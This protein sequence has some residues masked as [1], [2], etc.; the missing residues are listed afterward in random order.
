MAG[1]TN[2]L[3][4]YDGGRYRDA[5]VAYLQA[6]YNGNQNPAILFELTGTEP[7]TLDRQY[8]E[9]MRRE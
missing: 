9:F 5:L 3:V 8:R 2:F 7:K 4:Y 1:L 6:V